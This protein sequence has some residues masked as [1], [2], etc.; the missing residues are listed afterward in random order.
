MLKRE[1]IGICT[2]CAPYASRRHGSQN[3]ACARKCLTNKE[4]IWSRRADSNR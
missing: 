1:G 4:K 3:L 2:L